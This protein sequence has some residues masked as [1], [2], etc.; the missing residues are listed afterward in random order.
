[1]NVIFCSQTATRPGRRFA[2]A[3]LALICVVAH[4]ETQCPGYV[5][6]GAGSAFDLAG[7]I[8]DTGSP[9][10]ALDRV[11]KAV[12]KIDAGGGCSIFANTRAC[13]ETLNLAHKAIDALQTCSSTSAPKGT[14][15]G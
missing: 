7:I 12:S 4:A 14:S 2:V 1:M 3:V 10:L 8:K 11:R 6:T 15:H 9:Q 13:E 5:E